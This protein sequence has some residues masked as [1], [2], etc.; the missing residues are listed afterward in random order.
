MLH[1]YMYIRDKNKHFTIY[2][3]DTGLIKNKI[4]NSNNNNKC[5]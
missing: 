1:M 5:N 2:L 4:N 3:Q